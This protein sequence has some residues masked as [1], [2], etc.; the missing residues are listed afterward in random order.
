[1]RLAATR[2]VYEFKGE[3]GYSFEVVAEEVPGQG[4]R[5][6]VTMRTSG[7]VTAGD[8]VRHLVHSA[9]AFVRQVRDG[10]K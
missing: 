7:F 8:A 9:E 5:A 2:Q 6:S 10:V 4:W 3:D 1:V